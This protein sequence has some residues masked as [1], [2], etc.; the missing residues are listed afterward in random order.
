MSNRP[1]G[2][3]ALIAEARGFVPVMRI[4]A[5]CDELADSLASEHALRLSALDDRDAL[6]AKLRQ[7]EMQAAGL[8]G[9]YP[10]PQGEPPAAHIEAAARRLFGATVDSMDRARELARVALRAAA[11]VEIKGKP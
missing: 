2:V 7:S 9:I 8:H 3:D 4:S 6:D 1:T 10:P 5:L 11:D